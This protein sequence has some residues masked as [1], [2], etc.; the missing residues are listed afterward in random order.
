MKKTI[1]L[2]ENELISLIERMVKEY[3]NLLNRVFGRKKKIK[4]GDELLCIKNYKWSVDLSDTEYAS[5]SGY[6]DLVLDKLKGPK[7]Y[8]TK[9]KKYK[10]VG[11]GDNSVKLESNIGNP[12]NPEKKETQTFVKYDDNY[13]PELNKYFEV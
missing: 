5:K 13:F 8:F 4:V 3:G 7:Y 12:F 11:I 2:N 10:V 9:G 6:S 1:T